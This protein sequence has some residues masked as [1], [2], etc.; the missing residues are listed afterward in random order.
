MLYLQRQMNLASFEFQRIVR[1]EL[2]P[3]LNVDL[4]G[5][6]TVSFNSLEASN[7][8]NSILITLMCNLK[9][10]PDKVTVVS[11]GRV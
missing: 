2:R 6:N 7:R 11:D 5:Y 10:T 1:L 9:L 4:L 8:M 3:K